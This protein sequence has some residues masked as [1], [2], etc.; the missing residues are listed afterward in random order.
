MMSTFTLPKYFDN[1][2]EEKV[3]IYTGVGP[4][5]EKDE[6]IYHAYYQWVPLF[7]FFQCICFYASHALWKFWEGGKFKKLIASLE[8][9]RKNENKGAAGKED[10]KTRPC[11]ILLIEQLEKFE[12]T[13]IEEV[14]G[15]LAQIDLPILYLDYQIRL[16]KTALFYIQL[17]RSALADRLLSVTKLT[18]SELPENKMA[19]I[20]S[21][22]RVL[23]KI[24]SL[25]SDW[26]ENVEGNPFPP[27][28]N[29]LVFAG[30]VKIILESMTGTP[31]E[32][33][34]ADICALPLEERIPAMERYLCNGKPINLR[35]VVKYFKGKTIGHTVVKY[36]LDAF[37]DIDTTALMKYI[38]E[39]PKCNCAK[40]AKCTSKEGID[41]KLNYTKDEVMKFYNLSLFRRLY[42]DQRFKTIG[43]SMVKYLGK[44]LCYIDTTAL[45]KYIAEKLKCNCANG[46]KCTNDEGI[47]EK[48]NFTEDE[49]MKFYNLSLF[50][51][52]YKDQRFK[53]I[54][55]TVALILW[56][57]LGDEKGADILLH[58]FPTMTKCTFQKY[59]PSGTME[60]VDALC[61]LPVN[62]INEKIFFVLWFWFILL[63]CWSIA[64]LGFQTYLM[65][66]PSYRPRYCWMMSTF[67]LP[68]YFH[69]PTNETIYPGV[70][71]F[72][73]KDEKMYHAYYQ[74]VPL[75]LFFQCACFYAPQ[76]LW[77]CMEG[78]RFKKLVESLF[79]K[80]KDNDD[81]GDD[82]EDAG[83]KGG[84]T[85]AS[86]PPKCMCKDNDKKGGE[87]PLPFGLCQR[88]KQPDAIV[89]ADLVE[90]LV[91][92]VTNEDFKPMVQHL[93][94][95]PRK[96]RVP[97][98]RSYLVERK[99]LNMKQVVECFQ[100][101]LLKPNI[102]KYL[103]ERVSYL[104]TGEFIEW[105][106]NGPE[107]ISPLD[108]LKYLLTQAP[109]EHSA[110]KS[111]SVLV[112]HYNEHR[113]QDMNH[114]ICEIASFVNL[115]VQIM[116]TNLF[117]DYQFFSYGFKALTLLC[118]ES[119]ERTDILSIIFPTMTKCTFH[120]YGPSGT[121]ETLDSL[122]VLGVNIINEKIFLFLWV[123]FFL[124]A[125]CSLGNII[126]QT[127]L[128][129]KPDYEP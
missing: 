105:I 14:K 88:S 3:S 95:L 79:K 50:R 64:D 103:V 37:S 91:K 112:N 129:F 21:A 96:Y 120:K 29:N 102:V 17:A 122:C 81:D 6:K 49:D 87:K 117:L 2:T 118:G 9:V 42:K 104:D 60:N 113:C 33:M 24:D 15:V 66:K 108:M 80:K 55:Y 5:T 22:L 97:E 115:I 86:C 25:L 63:A 27:Q 98:M 73:G 119:K 48:L 47:D 90:F 121:I 28:H 70:G 7:L 8:I 59:G 44:P 53:T 114:Y 45:M 39:K 56:I 31:F 76:A 74:W 84:K 78:G 52:L 54:G 111:K 43:Y 10:S 20:S 67:T 72:T 35:Q 123:W 93:S 94:N 110:T 92:N 4:F 51:P 16:V 82:D 71:P 116:L 99:P 109:E 19:E 1:K 126:Y 101:K 38:E 85:G 125:V 75:F 106:E 13:E 65:F 11:L 30:V 36:L 69:T 61:V 58:I 68:K 26:I 12:L 32:D 34:V 57:V 23:G 83:E 100:G 62:V 18:T 124:L 89:L 46:A 40:G 107:E 127:Y 128:M 41:E 77:K